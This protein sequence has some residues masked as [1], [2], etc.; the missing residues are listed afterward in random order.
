M[1]RILTEKI[2]S[3]A[4]I[5][6]KIILDFYINTQITWIIRENMRHGFTCK[7]SS[8]D[9]KAGKSLVQEEQRVHG[10]TCL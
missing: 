5:N 10:E 9:D 8:L 6:S 1:L 4:K 7:P 2:N 3:S